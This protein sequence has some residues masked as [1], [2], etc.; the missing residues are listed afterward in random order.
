MNRIQLLTLLLF[1]AAAVISTAEPPADSTTLLGENLELVGT[2]ADSYCAIAVQ[3]NY[4]YLREWGLRP[5]ESGASATTKR[6]RTGFQIVDISDPSQPKRVGR[7]ELESQ[8]RR[9][10]VRGSVAYIP[11]GESGLKLLDISSPSAP[12][13]IGKVDTPGRAMCVALKGSKAYV[14]GTGGVHLLDVTSA[15][16]PKLLSGYDASP[17]MELQPHGLAVIG[18]AVFVAGGANGLGYLPHSKAPDMIRSRYAG[19]TFDE[20]RAVVILEKRAYVIEEG[21]TDIMET[22]GSRLM[23]LDLSNPSAPT[24]LGGYYVPGGKF[25]GIALEGKIAFISD[26][27]LGV[28]VIDISNPSAPDRIGGFSDILGGPFDITVVNGLVYIARLQDGL[29]ILRYNKSEI[30]GT[31]EQKF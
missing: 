25:T 21:W 5:E 14:G 6:Q 22:S 28:H 3:G 12:F 20:V 10:E 26:M 17:E 11:D 29:T 19:E 8:S 27:T 4:A 31:E 1:S 13:V 30:H 18:H 7:I 16:S 23:I 24:V 9:I 2:L 15:K